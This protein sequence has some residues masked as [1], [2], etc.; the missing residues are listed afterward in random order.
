MGIEMDKAPVL[1]LLV[2]VLEILT[3][4]LAGRNQQSKSDLVCHLYGYCDILSTEF[5]KTKEAFGHGS[6]TY[7]SLDQPMIEWV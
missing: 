5:N 2:D 4:F 3:D 1:P 7:Q 6:S